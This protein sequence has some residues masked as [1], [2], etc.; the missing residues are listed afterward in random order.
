MSTPFQTV[1]LHTLGCKVNFADSSTIGR[2]FR[3]KGLNVV[4]FDQP[5]DIYVLNTC[6]VTENANKKCRYIINKIIIC[7]YQPL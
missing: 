2:D 7:H 4:G 6:S 3:E 5:S 1:A